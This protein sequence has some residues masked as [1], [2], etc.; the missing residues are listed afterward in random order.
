M[1]ESLARTPLYDWH[2][3][4]G[5]RM[6]DFAGWAMPV[7]YGSIVE[8]H[9]ATRR[10]AGVFD[11]SHMARIR[12]DGQDSAALLDRLLTRRVSDLAPGRIRYSL[13]T[14]DEGGILDDVL[15]YHLETPSGRRYHLLVVNASNRQKVVDFLRQRGEAVGDAEMQDR[16]E[17]TAMISVQGKAAVQ[18]VASLV[19]AKVG[20]LGY[21][22]GVVTEQFGRPCAV[23][24]TGYTG[25]DG[26]ELIVR[27]EDALDVWRNIFRAGRELGVAAAGLGARDTLRLEAGMP[28]YGHELSE[29]IDPYQAG[30]GF[31][32]NLKDRA[33]PGCEALARLKAAGPLRVRVGLQVAGRRVPRE[34]YGV[35]R[36]QQ[37][38]LKKETGTTT[39]RVLA[40]ETV[41]A[42]VEPVP[43]VSSDQQ[44]VGEITSGTFSPTLQK[45]IAM[46]YVHPESSAPGTELLVDIRGHRE[47]AR[48]VPLPFYQRSTH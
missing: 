44:P 2:V 48:V 37:S 43:F 27:A 33:F 26:F 22:C 6:V 29:Q 28:L 40:S 14:N 8:E 12:F 23:S 36:D 30:L 24:R 10:A 20:D 13:V 15:V 35:Y 19:K 41:Q 32:V 3:E 11:V 46:A 18:I 45:S 38:L 16:T 4:H 47:P 17:E 34:H 42:V 31:A 21:Y 7:Q 39:N 9:Q 25:E 5:G 1:T